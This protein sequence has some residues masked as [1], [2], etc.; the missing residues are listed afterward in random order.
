MGCGSSTPAPAPSED[1]KSAASESKGIDHVIEDCKAKDELKI[2]MLLLGPGESG[3]STVFKQMRLLYG[4][5]RS[6]EDL[7][8]YGVAARS[9]ITVAIRKLIVHL[10]S[11]GLEQEL[12][13]ESQNEHTGLTPRQAYDELIAYL[14]DNTAMSAQ[15]EKDPLEGDWVGY[16]ARAGV[17]ANADAKLFL[18]HHESMKIIWEVRH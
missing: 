2:K 11:L 6:D 3:K 1:H 8:M 18:Q 17:G 15:D 12:E 10:R 9:N 7:R 5:E 13:K 14:V 4:T 16:S